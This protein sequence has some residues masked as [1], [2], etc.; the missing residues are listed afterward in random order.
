MVT[1]RSAERGL[2]L[3]TKFSINTLAS[4]QTITYVKEKEY[5]GL[6]F[7]INTLSKKH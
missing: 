7:I 1:Y 4:A 6:N 3:V 2:I 5:R